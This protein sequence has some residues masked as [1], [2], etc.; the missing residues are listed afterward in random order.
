MSEGDWIEAY[1]R[2]AAESLAGA[3]S[4]YDNGRFNNSANRA[5][6][7]A[8]QAAISALIRDGIWRNDGNW[9]HAFVQSEFI[10]RPINRRHR[11]PT[12]L[13]GTLADLQRYRHRADCRHTSITR[14]D[15]S[16]AVRRSSAFVAAV[17]AGSERQ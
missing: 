2:K 6:Y 15:A 14:S 16:T 11:Y 13:R 7:A 1:I 17:R 10:G 4:E 12:E 5:Y 8:F 9:P 3:Q